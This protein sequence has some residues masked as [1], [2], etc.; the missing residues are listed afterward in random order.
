MPITPSLLNLTPDDDSD[1]TRIDPFVGTVYRKTRTGHQTVEVG[2]GKPGIVSFIT[3]RTVWKRRNSSY[4][5]IHT[6]AHYKVTLSSD[7]KSAVRDQN[8]TV[9]D[10]MT[11]LAA[12]PIPSPAGGFTA[13]NATVV[14][15]GKGLHRTT[16]EGTIVRCLLNG[17]QCLAAS[18]KSGA[19]KLL[20]KF[21]S[22]E[23]LLTLG[24]QHPALRKTA[25]VKRALAKAQHIEECVS[26]PK[27]LY[28]A[29]LAGKITGDDDVR[30]TKIQN[31]R[32]TR[33]Q[34]SADFS[35]EPVYRSLLAA[36]IR[37]RFP[38]MAPL[39]ARRI[40]TFAAME[41]RVGAASNLPISERAFFATWAHL[42]H[43]QTGY[44]VLLR[45]GDPSVHLRRDI[46]ELSE[47]I[48]E[49]FDCGDRHYAHQLVLQRR[50]LWQQVE[51]I[52]VSAGKWHKFAVRLKIR[53]LMD[54]IIADLGCIYQPTNEVD[55]FF[56]ER[57]AL[58][59]AA[60]N[61]GVAA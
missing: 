12:A 53:P 50:D 6:D 59:I 11:V 32:R 16:K 19:T 28:Q 33:S 41:N 26:D 54:K 49:E 48:A 61:K 40:A 56:E 7:W 21:L 27:T 31:L 30:V 1:V 58:A 4:P 13:W 23:E 34:R 17:K 43:Q 51:H 5:N 52:N 10:G 29:A 37:H 38:L 3:S 8:L 39:Q 20:G 44:E 9:V 55:G 24:T 47:Q 57:D 45:Q 60:E 18:A 46:A 2:Q 25:P 14:V 15:G 35:N 36:E 42:R 22:Q